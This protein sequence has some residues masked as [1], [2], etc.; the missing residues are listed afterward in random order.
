MRFTTDYQSP[1]FFPPFRDS[2][3]SN[4]KAMAESSVESEEQRRRSSTLDSLSLQRSLN[5]IMNRL[6]A[7]LSSMWHEWTLNASSKSRGQ[8]FVNGLTISLASDTMD[9]GHSI[10]L[11]NN[12]S[13]TPGNTLV[14]RFRSGTRDTRAG[15]F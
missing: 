2:L 15:D 4:P 6:D 5:A 12:K 1:S 9:V 8:S 10:D 7:R 3:P 14:T 11:S 13:R